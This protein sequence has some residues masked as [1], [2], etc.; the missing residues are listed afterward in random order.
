MSNGG[1]IWPN[2]WSSL[3]IEG[4]VAKDCSEEV[5][6]KHAQYGHICNW[7]HAS[8]GG[9]DGDKEKQNKKNKKLEKHQDVPTLSQT[10]TSQ[11]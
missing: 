7:L 11:F 8:F 10:R 2:Q 1:R 5:H 6:D 9:T 3:T 4:E